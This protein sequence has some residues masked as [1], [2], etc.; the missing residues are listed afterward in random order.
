MRTMRVPIRLDPLPG[1]AFDSWIDAYAQRLLMPGRDLAHVLGVC[2]K[3]VRLR[4]CNVAKGDSNLDAEQIAQR[5][6]D[7][8]P[9]ASRGLPRN[10]TTHPPRRTRRTQPPCPTKEP[11]PVTPAAPADRLSIYPRSQQPGNGAECPSMTGPSVHLR[12][13]PSANTPPAI[14]IG[15]SSGSLPLNGIAVN[16]ATD[17]IYALNTADDTVSVIDGATCDVSVTTGCGQTPPT[18]P[19]GHQNVGGVAG[20]V[21]V[22]P[23]RNLVYVDD[24]LDDTV[25]VIDGA[26]CDGT[27]TTGCAQPPPT[28]PGGP[29][30]AAIAVNPLDGTVYAAGNG[31][32]VVSFFRFIPPHRPTGLTASRAGNDVNL[33]WNRAYDGGLPIVYHVVALPACPSCTGLTTPST[34][35]QPFTT[36]SGLASGTTYTFKVR[37]VDAAGAGPTSPASNPVRP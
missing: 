8:D 23:A 32:G 24:G 11:P 36:I 34:S 19:V 5:A 14:P 26:S 33:S 13:I 17:T 15:N 25:S 28:V 21:A 29:Q 27:N 35:G 22:D 10:R 6:C 18:V 12:S 30:P 9:A 4:G 7:I 31:G 20:G 1:E 2:E 37:G 16:D 3:L